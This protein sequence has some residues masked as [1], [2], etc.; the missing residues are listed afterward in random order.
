MSNHYSMKDI[1]N[2][3]DTFLPKALQYRKRQQWIINFLLCYIGIIILAAI[4]LAK[5]N[6][7]APLWL[8]EAGLWISFISFFI[9]VI[10]LI[11]HNAIEHYISF[12]SKRGKKQQHISFDSALKSGV[13]TLY[14]KN[15]RF[16]KLI[17]I[18]VRNTWSEV[19]EVEYLTAVKE[20]TVPSI[21]EAFEYSAFNN[22]NELAQLLYIKKTANRNRDHFVFSA[23]KSKKTK[24]LDFVLKHDGN[25]S[26]LCEKTGKSALTIAIV[27]W[28]TEMVSLL[29]QHGANVNATDKKGHTP[30]YYAIKEGVTDVVQMLIKAGADTNKL[31]SATLFHETAKSGNT[32]IAKELVQNGIPLTDAHTTDKTLLHIAAENGH[33]DYAQFLLELGVSVSPKDKTGNT[34]LILAARNGFPQMV[35]HLLDSGADPFEKTETKLNAIQAAYL[36]NS[37]E[38]I[39]MLTPYYGTDYVVDMLCFPPEAQ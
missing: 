21:E 16:I 38:T 19:E 30:L 8:Q 18:F 20:K 3:I 35:K 27:S 37:T 28:K 12:L 29:I 7:D 36:C 5:S 24:L 4:F 15:T 1:T 9:I 2:N 13:F 39:E 17:G 32:D 11:V 22:Y 33:V 14:S 34:P 10:S 26:A 25:S 23:L 31:D 6:F